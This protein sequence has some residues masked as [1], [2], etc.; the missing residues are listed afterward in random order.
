MNWQIINKEAFDFLEQQN[1]YQAQEK[2]KYN[3]K[4]NICGETLHNLGCF[5]M[6]EGLET[7]NHQTRSAPF[8]GYHYLFH[9]SMIFSHPLNHAALAM[10][11]Y[12]IKDYNK[13]CEYYKKISE[14]EI[15]SEILYNYAVPCFFMQLYQKTV[16]TLNKAIQKATKE[17]LSKMITLLIHGLLCTDHFGE[18]KEFIYPYIDIM[19]YD[20]Q[21]ILLFLLHEYDAAYKRIPFL[22]KYDLSFSELSM[23]IECAEYYY[24]FDIIKTLIKIKR[25]I[26]TDISYKKIECR[27]IISQIEGSKNSRKR[28]ID[29]YRYIPSVIPICY[30]I[31]CSNHNLTL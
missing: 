28:F 22:Y 11:H 18:A 24:N 3:A 26:I 12:N 30:Y 20:D 13:S 16:S 14:R 5:Y 25:D 27:K 17:N 8:L 23:A 9:A 31:D 10:Y 7:Q 1:Y 4:N 6:E 21:F 29:Q 2:F 19:D 15:T